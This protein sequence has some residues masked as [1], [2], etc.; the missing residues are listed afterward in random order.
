M[1]ENQGLRL[2]FGTWYTVLYPNMDTKIAVPG[3]AE[4]VE[5]LDERVYTFILDQIARREIFPGTRLGEEEYAR[6]CQVSRSPVRA[7][8]RRLAQEGVVQIPA[9]RGAVLRSPSINELTELYV[10][11]ESVEGYI[12][13]CAAPLATAAVI[14][15]LRAITAEERQHYL[16]R[17]PAGGLR[18][19]TEFHMAVAQLSGLAWSVKFLREM[20]FQCNIFH[21]F[22]DRFPTDEPRS[23][24]EHAALITALESRD[25]ELAKAAAVEHVRSLR[26]NHL[27]IPNNGL[28]DD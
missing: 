24:K 15:H 4:T 19:S 18:L 14:E 10:L 7:A 1:A 25:S 8:L 11:R 20:L 13:S 17:D 3:P 2:G 9:G 26:A 23:T 5:R 22:Y 27:S 16:D 12:A 21:L 6:H 28:D